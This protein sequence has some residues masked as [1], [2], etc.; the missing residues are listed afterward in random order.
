MFKNYFK[1]AWRNLMKNKVF[2]FINILGLT[3]GITVCMMIFLFIMNEFSVD[4]FHKNGDSIYRVMRGAAIDDKSISVAY[5]S[6]MYAPALLNDFKGEIISA[7]RVSQNDN[8]FT[9]GAKSFHEK[10]ELDVDTG[11]F[12]LFSFPLIKGNPTTVLKDPNSVVLTETTAKKYFGSIDNAM[13]KIIMLNKETPLKVTGIAKDVPSNSHLDFDI[14]MPLERHK[15][16]GWMT[17]WINNGVYTYIQLAPNVSQA[18]IEKQ[19]PAF[20]EK[21]LGSDMRK[22]GFKWS[23]SLTPL[24]DVYFDSTGLDNAKHGD[25][26]VVYI[27]LSIAILILLIACINFMNL[28]TIRAVERSKEVGLRKVLGA[29]RNNL[30]WQFIGE[31]VLLTTISCILSVG[32]LLLVM[33][34]YN[35]LLG[36]YIN[37]IMEC[38]A[39][40]FISCWYHYCRW[41]FSRQLSCIFLICILTDTGIKRKIKIGQRRFIFQAG[42]SSCAIQHIS[43]FDC[44]HHHHYKTNELC[45][46]QTT[47]I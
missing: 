31:S 45:K 2:S 5:L 12:S 27:F 29:L 35:Q 33:P 11:F 22:Y 3:I 41:I 26:T 42:F 24:K 8:L 14:V 20:V 4:K 18:Q 40:L 9:V 1:T 6:G 7:V 28:S 43:I 34:W 46:E 19:L 10:K 36:L 38:I 13:G 21:Y 44:W 25:K 47:W 30:V 17:T 37:C 32:L 16:A 15:D 39:H 23:L